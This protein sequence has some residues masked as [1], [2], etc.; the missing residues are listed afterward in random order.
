MKQ[1]IVIPIVLLAILGFTVGGYLAGRHSH[2]FPPD[3]AT[4]SENEE[5]H[6]W[7]CSMHPFIIRDEPGLCPICGMDL[8][9]VQKGA[10]GGESAGVTIDP[11]TSQNMGV[12]IAP[13]MRQD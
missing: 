5:A 4:V 9:P 3:T 12:R 10:G 13:V 2:D 7:T 6:Q 1:K 11:A 8:V